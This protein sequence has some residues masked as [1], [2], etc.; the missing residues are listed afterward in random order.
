MQVW[1]LLGYIL[2]MGGVICQ[3]QIVFIQIKV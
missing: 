1:L 3:C 2:G